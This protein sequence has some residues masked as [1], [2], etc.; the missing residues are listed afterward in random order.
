MMQFLSRIGSEDKISSYSI[1]TLCG[2]LVEHG[3]MNIDAH[4]RRCGPYQEK[5]TIDTDP[6]KARR[7]MMR[8]FKTGKL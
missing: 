1:C 5:I 4:F 3:V 7:D 6:E 8:F 2:A